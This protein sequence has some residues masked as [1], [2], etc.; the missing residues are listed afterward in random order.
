MEL[1]HKRDFE[2]VKERWRAFWRRENHGPLVAAVVP[3]PGVEPVDKPPY[4]SGHDGNF[5]PVVDQ[6]LRWA[7][8][9]EFLGDAIPYYYLEFAADHFSTLLGTDLRFPDPTMGGWP[10]HWVTDWQSA[11]IRFRPDGKW[12]EMT[13]RFAEELK[14]RAS[15]K[16]L[17]ASPSLVSNLDA[18]VAMAGA[19]RVLLDLAERPDEIEDAL[20]R[21]SKAHADILDAFAELFE[22]DT[23]GSI[24]RHGMWCDGRI[25]V[26]QSDFSCMLSAEM[27]DRFVFPSISTETACLDQ[28][29]YHL[30]GPDAIRHTERICSIPELDIMQWVPGAG[31]A[32]EQ[33]WTWLY[34]KFDA[35]G[36]GQ[37][38]GGRPERIERLWNRFQ[39][40]TVFFNVGGLTGSPDDQRREVRRLQGLSRT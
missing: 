9:H 6:I 34:E 29:E 4:G 21:V 22:Y 33:D 27:F 37:I 31:E 32:Q 5:A 7:E 12:W 2:A 3:K 24:N 26:V 15:G 25:N 11:D 16:I 28:S 38:L 19:N 18:L 40:R 17:I 36:K 30:D 14:A 35:L 23:W 10:V 13:A 39:S 8:T 1:A 20:K